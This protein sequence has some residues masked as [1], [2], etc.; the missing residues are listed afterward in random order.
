MP[1][2]A[3]SSYVKSALLLSLLR[4]CLLRRGFLCLGMCDVLCRRLPWPRRA[5]HVCATLMFAALVRLLH[6]LFFLHQLGRLE[7][8]P[9]KSNLSNTDRGIILSVSTQ[10]LVL[11]LAFVVEDQ[12]LLAAS[13]LYHLA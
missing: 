8:L 6:L 12:D 11:L 7:R 9:I 1:A 3:G 2:V 13:L 5:F 4:R 10:L